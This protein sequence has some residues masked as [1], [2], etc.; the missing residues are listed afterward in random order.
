MII[1][2]FHSYG[3]FSIYLM[4]HFI[5]LGTLTSDEI[6]SGLFDGIICSLP[7]VCLSLRLRRS[8]HDISNTSSCLL[9]I[10]AAWILGILNS[11]ISYALCWCTTGS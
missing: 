4:L 5:L 1:L 6:H 10:R 2:L 7:F 11:I 8:H 9:Q 3:S